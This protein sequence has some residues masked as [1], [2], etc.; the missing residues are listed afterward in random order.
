MTVGSFAVDRANGSTSAL[1]LWA[2]F[3]V[4]TFS[5][6]PRFWIDVRNGDVPSMCNALSLSPSS[7]ANSAIRTSVTGALPASGRS[8]MRFIGWGARDRCRTW[9]C[10]SLCAKWTCLRR[11]IPACECSRMKILCLFASHEG[12]RSKRAV[13]KSI[14]RMIRICCARNDRRIFPQALLRI[15]DDLHCRPGIPG[16]P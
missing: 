7:A 10:A 11:G 3:I 12:L 8:A 9:R 4:E 16:M 15:C 2:D 5:A 14:W 6:K 1:H 13:A